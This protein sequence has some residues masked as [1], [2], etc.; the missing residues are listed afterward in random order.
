MVEVTA[1]TVTK[2]DGVKGVAVQANLEGNGI[3]IASESLAAIQGIMKN[4]KDTD[5]VLHT[6]VLRALADVPDI[7]LC[8]ETKNYEMEMAH[9]MDKCVVG[10]GELN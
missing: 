3:E 4:L 7:L 6:V 5:P 9:L 1:K 10:K 2:E 8:K